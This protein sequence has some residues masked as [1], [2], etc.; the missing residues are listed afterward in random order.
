MNLVYSLFGIIA[1][2]IF[3]VMVDEDVNVFSERQENEDTQR[4][5]LHDL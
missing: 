5:T 3:V 4:K 1:T 2:A